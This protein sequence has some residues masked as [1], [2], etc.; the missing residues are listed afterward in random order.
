MLNIICV[1]LLGLHRFKASG[2]G[3]RGR[4]IKRTCQRCGEVKYI[5]LKEGK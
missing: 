4:V 5:K 1:P 2:Y 3:K